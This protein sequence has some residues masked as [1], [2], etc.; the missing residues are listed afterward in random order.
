MWRLGDSDV[1]LKALRSDAD[2]ARRAWLI[3]L[4]APL[5]ITTETLQQHAQD[6][7]RQRRATGPPFGDGRRN[8][9]A[10]PRTGQEQ[11]ALEAS[12]LKLYRDDPD[13]GVHSACRWLLR[14]RLSAAATLERLDRSL[15]GQ[16]NPAQRWYVG[17]NGHSFSVFRGPRTFIMGSPANELSREE[18]EARHEERL[19]HSFTISI[20]E[21]TIAQ[22]L[23]VP[24]QDLQSPI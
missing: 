18:D 19:E 11:E 16:I 1:A 13:A 21:V 20:E 10:K 2:P 22:F 8:R 12:L 9:R 6:S 4:L 5:G 3:E 7:N 24:R 15:V 23:Q 17:P 14:T